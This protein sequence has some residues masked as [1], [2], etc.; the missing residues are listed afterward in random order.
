VIGNQQSGQ[1]KEAVV[2]KGGN[3]L[4]G[5]ELWNLENE[6]DRDEEKDCSRFSWKQ[7]FGEGLSFKLEMLDKAM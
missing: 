1:K 4:R 2:G 7:K 3:R 5:Y 6:N